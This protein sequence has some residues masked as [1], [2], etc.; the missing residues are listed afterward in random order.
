MMYDL[1]NFKIYGNY[2]GNLVALE[3]GEEFPFDIKRVYYIWG[4]DKDAV[5]GRHAHRKLEQV[6]I[7]TSGSCDFILDDGKERTTIHL[8]NPAQGLYIKGYIWR[9]FTNFS[10]DCVVVVLASEHYD[11]NDYI[12]DY[13]TFLDE[14][15]K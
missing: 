15:V 8:D 11:E 13:Q 1:L 4:T 10:P 2:A 6:V 7:C 14:I 3:K 9:E 12:R 5:R